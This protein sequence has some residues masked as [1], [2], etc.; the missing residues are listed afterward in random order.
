VPRELPDES[1]ERE[2]PAEPPREPGEGTGVRRRPHGSAGLR[3]ADRRL[4]R[5]VRRRSRGRPSALLDRL[6]HALAAAA[7]ARR[8][9]PQQRVQVEA[10]AAAEHTAPEATCRCGIYACES[11]AEGL[12]RWCPR[13][14]EEGAW[15]RLSA[16]VRLALGQGGRVPTRLA[17]RARLPASIYVPLLSAQGRLLLACSPRAETVALALGS[18]S[19]PIESVA[20]EAVAG[21]RAEAQGRACASVSADSLSGWR[22]DANERC[23]HSRREHR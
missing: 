5:L 7:G 20:C 19:V 6:P 16:R 15:P 17:R 8:E 2:E 22:E 10:G 14:A 21:A 4:A 13:A 23:S 9:L 1:A 3:R 18:Y 11:A 12:P